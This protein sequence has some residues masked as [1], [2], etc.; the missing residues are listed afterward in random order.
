VTRRWLVLLAVFWSGLLAVAQEQ[1]PTFMPDV[2]FALWADRF[3]TQMDVLS[4]VPLVER[5]RRFVEYMREWREE[6]MPIMF[7]FGALPP[8]ERRQLGRQMRQRLFEQV[9][10]ERLVE[11]RSRWQDEM[12]FQV[13]AFQSLDDVGRQA[14]IRRFWSASPPEEPTL[15]SE[16]AMTA[17][18]WAVVSDLIRQIRQLQ[19]EMAAALRPHRQ[20]LERLLNES[21][22]P[23][24]DF[25]QELEALRGTA[26]RYQ[27]QLLALRNALRQLLTLEQEARLTVA[28]VLD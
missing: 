25:A 4:V 11:L 16:L 5:Q 12:T 1:E 19:Q 7:V 26:G 10:A 21:G 22:T 3:E 13:I 2:D 18:E 24:T 23:A 8:E 27:V 6:V 20:A 17:E 28:G 14:L 15:Q 9:G